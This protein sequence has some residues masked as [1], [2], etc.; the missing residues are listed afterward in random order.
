[1]TS[2]DWFD[3]HWLAHAKYLGLPENPPRKFDYYKYRN[4]A[5]L[6][7]LGCFSSARS[8]SDGC[9]A[10]PN[11]VNSTREFHAH[12]LIHAYMEQLGRPP[13]LFVEGIA[14][15][16]DCTSGAST[17]TPPL[18]GEWQ[19]ALLTEQG[20]LD[21]I[22]T[23]NLEGPYELA[24]SFVGHLVR[25]NGIAAFV[26][27]YSSVQRTASLET[28]RAA[29]ER[30]YGPYD[31]L[32]ANWIDEATR[33]P[34]ANDVQCIAECTS[35]PVDAMGSAA[36]FEPGC[37]LPNPDAIIK[38]AVRTFTIEEEDTIRLR[39]SSEVARPARV[40]I[41]GCNGKEA[42]RLVAGVSPD[43]EF[44]PDSPEAAAELWATLKPG[45]YYAA[46][47]FSRTLGPATLGIERV[48]PA[49]LVCP[50]SS[51]TP[52]VPT[53][54][55][56][57][58]YFAQPLSSASRQGAIQFRRADPAVE[59]RGYDQFV[60][61]AKFIG[62]VL[63]D[64]GYTQCLRSDPA[65]CGFPD[66]EVFFSPTPPSFE[67]CS[68]APERQCGNENTFPNLPAGASS[69][70]VFPLTGD[71]VSM[72]WQLDAGQELSFGFRLSAPP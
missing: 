35:P 11:V 57:L 56:N 17:R 42:A 37:N 20:F 3:H 62:R 53:P 12:E 26:R 6:A 69:F 10:A 60:Q 22:Q 44:F 16:L 8:D 9:F 14:I 59:V 43:P 40:S 47:R 27:F 54:V 46:V 34:E 15:Y 36:S 38:G 19:P 49:T 33:R 61:G 30:E 72:S 4:R 21:L 70:E 68:C 1:L 66:S 29:L 39:I 18:L 64:G 41:E 52:V 51:D 23:Q 63:E 45:S 25:R 31:T 5:E 13:R 7:E 65:V 32:I 50:G 71:T 28:V 58:F 2:L 48:P 55:S 24:Y 67:L